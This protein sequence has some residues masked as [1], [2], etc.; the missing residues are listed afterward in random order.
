MRGHTYRIHITD[1]TRI[2]KATGLEKRNLF[3]SIHRKRCKHIGKGIARWRRRPVCWDNSVGNGWRCL[4]RDRGSLRSQKFCP[5]FWR[6][7]R[8]RGGLGSF[9]GA[10]ARLRSR[11]C[12]HGGLVEILCDRLDRL[13]CGRCHTDSLDRL[14]RDEWHGRLSRGPSVRVSSPGWAGRRRKHG[15]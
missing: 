9:L 12:S 11:G 10:T 3:I 7:F 15:R 14:D 8:R 6:C 2:Y 4:C 13:L 1:I 5:R